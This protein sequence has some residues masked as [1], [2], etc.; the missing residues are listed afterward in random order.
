MLNGE[1]ISEVRND[2]RAVIGDAWIPSKYIHVKLKSVASLF[3][4]READ[5]RRLYKY[6]NLWTPVDCL[7][8]K[9]SDLI[10]CCNIDIPSC[11]TVMKSIKKLPEIFSTRFGYL[12]TVSSPDYDKIYN[13]TTPTGYKRILSREF[14]DKSQRYFWFEGGHIVIPNSI[15]E[16]I[17]VNMLTP[18]KLLASQLDCNYSGSIRCNNV[19]EQEFVAP[20][21]MIS[22]IKKEVVKQII[23]SYKSVQPDEFTNLNENQKNIK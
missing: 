2:V 14:N 23:S 4:K 15:V 20:D 19:L 22:D 12:L 13:Q 9:E 5:D 16:I 1:I 18:D 8:M 21:Y 7:K 11:K 17:R 6:P 10:N 3:I